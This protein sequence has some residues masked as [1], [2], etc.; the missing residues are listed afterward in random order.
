MKTPTMYPPKAIRISEDVPAGSGTTAHGTPA[1]SELATARPSRAVFA[2]VVVGHVPEA[3]PDR[4]RQAHAP[5]QRHA[6]ENPVRHA[7]DEPN[8][9]RV[10]VVA[11]H[12]A[13]ADAPEQSR[14]PHDH[15][16]RALAAGV[17]EQP[18]FF[19]V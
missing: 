11:H 10:A 19:A 8:G 16:E 13:A 3:E 6:P 7:I 14:R 4:E 2:Q 9:R 5:G 18:Q 15:N 12:V 17:A 1:I